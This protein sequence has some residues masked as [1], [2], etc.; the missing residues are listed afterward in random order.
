LDGDNSPEVL[1]E[2][3]ELRAQPGKPPYGEP[4]PAKG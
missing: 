4:E 3:N 1:A 2:I